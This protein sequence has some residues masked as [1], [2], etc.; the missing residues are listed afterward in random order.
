VVAVAAVEAGQE[1][2]AE[3]AAAA[4]GGKAGSLVG[5]E[6]GKTSNVGQEVAVD[7]SDAVAGVAAAG[8]AGAGVDVAAPGESAGVAAATPPGGAV[9]V[10]AV[11]AAVTNSELVV[12]EDAALPWLALTETAAM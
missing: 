4:G 10:A 12:H 7:G 1:T 5:E 11:A 3:L 9:A 8:G 6:T 2:A